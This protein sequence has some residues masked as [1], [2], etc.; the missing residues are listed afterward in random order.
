MGAGSPQGGMGGMQGQGPQATRPQQTPM[1]MQ[2][3]QAQGLGALQNAYSSFM[4][5]QPQQPNPMFNQQAQNTYQE[6]QQAAMGQAPA[7]PPT[8]AP[9]A[10]M[11]PPA[12]PMAPPPMQQ[13]PMFNQ[14][15]PEDPR[16]QAMRNMQRGGNFDFSRLN[17]TNK[18]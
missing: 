9:Q 8:G 15:R 13:A 3:Q 14:V 7:S 10:P 11:A 6:F 12:A 2:P 1:Q 16:M 18:V 4:N 5:T 17:Y